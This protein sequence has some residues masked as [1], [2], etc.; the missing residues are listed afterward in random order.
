MRFR[1]IQAIVAVGLF[2]M[3][4]AALAADKTAEGIWQG[5]LSINGG[6]S[7]RLVV[8][9][10][11]KGDALTGSMDSLDQGAKGIAIKEVLFEGKKLTLKMPD[12]MASFDGAMNDAGT[13][14]AGKFTQA[15]NE[16]PLTLARND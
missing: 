6:I 2:A 10:S 8:H 13:E 3:S 5:K 9:I 12:L 1:L 4:T 15:G 16:L 11:K 14:I 7:L